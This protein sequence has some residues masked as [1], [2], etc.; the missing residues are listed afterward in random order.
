MCDSSTY[1]PLLLLKGWSITHEY[2]LKIEINL[3]GS[4]ANGREMLG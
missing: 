2:A 1:S 4:V 3:L